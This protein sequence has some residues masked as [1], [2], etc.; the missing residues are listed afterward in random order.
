MKLMVIVR[1]GQS[2]SVRLY[3]TLQEKYPATLKGGK[4]KD[5]NV[6]Q[7]WVTLENGTFYIVVDAKDSLHVYDLCWEIRHVGESITVQV[8]PVMPSEAITELE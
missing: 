7:S 4:A 6:E 2:D 3:T 5:F 1:F 8:V